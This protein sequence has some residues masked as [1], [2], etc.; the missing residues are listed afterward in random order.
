ME[1]VVGLFEVIGDLE[2]V[3]GVFG[4]IGVREGYVEGLGRKI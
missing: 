4:Y 2:G 1:G 3:V